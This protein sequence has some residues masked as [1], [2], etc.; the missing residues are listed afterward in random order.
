MVL[1]AVVAVFI[2]IPIFYYFNEPFAYLLMV[3]D[4]S[5]LVMY[6]IIKNHLLK[7]TTSSNIIIFIFFI[8]MLSI[9]AMNGNDTFVMNWIILYPI[10]VFGLKNH[11]DSIIHSILFLTVF[12]VMYY[13]SLLHESYGFLDVTMVGMM[14]V[15]LTILLYLIIKNI[16]LNEKEL[17]ELNNT[18]EMRI[19]D[20]IKKNREKEKFILQQN[21]L[22]QMGEMLSMIAH[23]WRQPLNIISL[24]TVKL[25]AAVLLNDAIDKENIKHI[26]EAINKQSQYLSHTI[27]DFR[28]FF[29]PNKGASSFVVADMVQHALKLSESIF[30]QNDIVVKKYIDVK[31]EIFSFESELIQVLLNIIKNA[32]D[33]LVESDKADKQIVISIS[34]EDDGVL[35]S[36]LDNAGG[37][38]DMAISKIFDPYFSTK[39]IKGTGLGLYMS[40]IIVEDHCE[41]A[42]SFYNAKDGACFNIKLPFSIKD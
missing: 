5:Y 18:L 13:S 28:N 19:S 27:D 9:P 23:Q 11:I 15:V 42:L 32:T 29:K 6:L 2:N 41:G 33:A 36:I 37:V 10:V 40:K 20:A 24:N 4:I 35:I 38:A 26:S 3:I 7:Y 31:R 25:D 34:E 30:S 22:A 12:Y 21:R 14:Y 16:E 17:K 8:H 1:V 39:S